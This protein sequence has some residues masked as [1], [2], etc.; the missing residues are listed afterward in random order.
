[1]K[2]VRLEPVVPWS[3]VKHSTNESLR[4]HIRWND[5]TLDLLNPELFARFILTLSVKELTFYD[6]PHFESLRVLFID[7][8]P[9][10]GYKSKHT[11][12]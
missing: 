1:M 9:E 3:R 5:A 8:N 12:K 4:S 11:N 6:L 10:P 2:P 7:Q